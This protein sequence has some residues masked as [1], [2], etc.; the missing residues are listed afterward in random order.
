MIR[1]L[2]TCE[3]PPQTG[4]VSDYTYLIALGLANRGEEV[5]VWCPGYHGAEPDTRGIIVHRELGAMKLPDLMR[6][7]RQLNDFPPSRRIL[8]QWV[9]HGYGYRSMNLVFCL[10]VLYRAVVRRDELEIMVHEPFLPFGLKN[11]R[12]N[13]LAAIHRLMTISLLRGV[14]RV[15]VAIPK[16]EPLLRP[17]TLWRPVSFRWLPVPSS[18]RVTDDPATVYAIR[19]KY[20]DGNSILIGHF[21]TYGTAITAALEDILISLAKRPGKRKLLLMGHRSEE[22]CRELIARRPELVGV[23]HSTGRLP[24]RSVSLHVA[25]CDLLIQPYPDGVS[26]R[27]TSTMLGLS[28][29]KPVVTTSG[30]LTEAIWLDSG[31]VAITPWGDPMRIVKLVEELENNSLERDRLGAA[32]LHLYKEC[33]DI[34]HTIEAL[35]EES[36]RKP[37]PRTLCAS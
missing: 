7:G 18:I 17:Y 31:A 24:E 29:G 28:H 21:G 27:R 9:P 22:F 11:G 37:L 16:W 20:I 8:L 19:T 12:H 14:R 13:V 35:C 10:W 30:H 3:Y 26:T 33:F 6:V 1:H 34:S 15:W 32:A 4:G 2:I 23:I 36:D 25:A 5:H